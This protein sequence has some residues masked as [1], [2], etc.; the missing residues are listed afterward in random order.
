MA[1]TGGECPLPDNTEVL[2]GNDIIIKK[3]LEAFAQV[4]QGMDA[5]ID[6]EGPAIHVIYE[7]IWS[8]QILLKKRG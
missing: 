7:P 1:F 6:S 2:H 8:G 3:T 5:A 4:K